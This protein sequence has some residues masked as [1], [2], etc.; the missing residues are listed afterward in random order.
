MLM[1]SSVLAVLDWTSRPRVRVLVVYSKEDDQHSNVVHLLVH[2]LEAQCH[3]D[4]I[5][6]YNDM[7]SIAQDSATYILHTLD[8]ADKILLV[9]SDG[10]SRG[11]DLEKNMAHSGS[12]QNPA[13]DPLEYLTLPM[14]R[15]MRSRL[16]QDPTFANKLVRSN[17]FILPTKY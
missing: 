15:G 4:V 16:Q 14:L 7:E 1:F 5:I 9:D 2:F 17:N 10:I 12:G 3:C 6:D 13:S 8:R 11:T